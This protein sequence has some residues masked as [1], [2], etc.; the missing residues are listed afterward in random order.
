MSEWIQ[1]L[2]AIAAGLTAAQHIYRKGIR[3]VIRAANTFTLVAPVLIDIGTEFR[4][5]SGTSLHDTIHTMRDDVNAIMGDVSTIKR[6]LDTGNE[7][8]VGT[9]S[10]DTETRRIRRIPLAERTYRE[11]RH[12]DHSASPEPPIGSPR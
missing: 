7:G 11:Q 3:P 8:T 5:N 6:Q 2:V 12:E 10:D 1:W 9:N 4:P